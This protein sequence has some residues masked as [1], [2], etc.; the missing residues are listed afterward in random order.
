MEDERYNEKK[1]IKFF[2]RLLVGL[3][4][5]KFP[6]IAIFIF[7]LGISTPL[8]S[9]GSGQLN[10]SYFPITYPVIEWTLITVSNLR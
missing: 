1:R 6:I 10:L 7:C 8:E 5:E 9:S 3:F 2:V 4:N